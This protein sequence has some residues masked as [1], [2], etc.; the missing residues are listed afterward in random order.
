MNKINAEKIFYAA[1]N[2]VNPYNAVINNIKIKGSTLIVGD[3]ESPS[4][5]YDLSHFKQINIV[6]CGKAAWPM[7]LAMEKIAG[8]HISRGLA[9][10]K[11]NYV[12]TPYPSGI[13]ILEAGHPYPDQSGYDATVQTLKILESSG[14]D[15]LVIALISGGGSSLWA[16]PVSPISLEEFR[17]TTR[18]L[19]GCGAD[20]K[21]I[22]CVRKHLSAISGGLAAIKAYPAKVIVLVISDV[23]GDHLDTIG[24]GPFYPD[25]TTFED[26]LKVIKKY[27]IDQKIPVSVKKYIEQGSLGLQPETPKRGSICFNNVFHKTIASNRSALDAAKKCAE[28]LGFNTVV[29]NDPTS[30]EAKES[31]RVFCEKVKEI[32]N[33]E[34][35]ERMCVIAGGETTVTLGSESGVGGRNQ[36]FA[37]AAALEIAGMD[38]ITILSCGTDGTDGP[39]DANGAIVDGKTV[40]SCR[41]ARLHLHEAL[42]KHDSYTL[43]SNSG[44]LI[45]TGPTYTNVMDLQIA[46][47]EKQFGPD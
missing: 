28:E 45:K 18:V 47:I 24:S 27:N 17:E 33:R 34:N 21:E 8:K 25:E 43:F 36:E 32:R 11:Y 29:I 35:S 23:I 19:V 15:D 41:K 9:V 20:I 44:N 13:E 42:E 40:E 39:T 3:E 7:C 4:V 30:G 37:L 22:N 14:E 5:S 38:G 16:L 1:L 2:A 26:A 31:A 46:I 10:T 12:S 6:G